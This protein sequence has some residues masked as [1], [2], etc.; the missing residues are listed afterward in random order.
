MGE[1]HQNPPIECWQRRI[2]Q[3]IESMRDKIR[4][5]VELE[6]GASF[7]AGTGAD[8]C[9]YSAFEDR[10]AFDSYAD[11]CSTAIFAEYFT[12]AAMRL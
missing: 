12:A 8:L 4:G 10:A 11:Q 9:L 3:E 2:K 6:V 7:T 5:L 1:V